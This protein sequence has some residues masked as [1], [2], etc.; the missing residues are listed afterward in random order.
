MVASDHDRRADLAALHELVDALAELGALAVAEPAHARRQALERNALLRE[1]DPARKC[2]VVREQL[3]HETV[4]ARDVLLIAGE[5]DPTERAAAFGE[6]WA[7]VRRDGS[8]IRERL[9]VARG[10]R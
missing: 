1:A 2:L 6:E 8:R 9:R 4:G 10:L 5:R 7:D 3:G